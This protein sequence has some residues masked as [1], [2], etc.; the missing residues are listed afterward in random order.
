MRTYVVTRLNFRKQVLSLIRRYTIPK[1]LI[2]LSL[3][4]PT[5]HPH[6]HRQESFSLPLN[7]LNAELNP[8]CH[9]LASLGAHHIFH[10]SELRVNL[11][12]FLFVILYYTFSVQL[13]YI[14][15]D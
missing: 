6:P 13:C 1:M 2:P 15:K 12:R 8:I 9:L 5:F 7:L 4:F 14:H 11:H 10:V 3:L